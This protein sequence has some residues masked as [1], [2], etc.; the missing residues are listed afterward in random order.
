VFHLYHRVPLAGRTMRTI[1][2][3]TDVTASGLP[4]PKVVTNMRIY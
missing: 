3:H 1:G 2:I 4:L